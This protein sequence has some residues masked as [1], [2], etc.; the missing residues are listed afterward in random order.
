LSGEDDPIPNPNPNAEADGEEQ[1]GHRLITALERLADNGRAERQGSRAKLR[2]ADPFDGKDPKK[3]RG[4]LLQCT[5]NFHARPQDFRHDS[6]K[7]N[8]ALSFLKELALDYFEPYLVDDVADEPLWV[9][10]YMA[11]TEELYKFFGPYDQV[12]DA[13]VELE[14]LVM[15]DNH[16][17]TRFF[18]QYQ[19]D[20]RT[21]SGVG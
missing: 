20:G 3:L 2:E 10:D 12:A 9:S 11:F 7:V 18:I 1:V 4:F 13:E 15:K 21:P 5:L 19:R 17:A 14:N 6:M 8:Y 16:K